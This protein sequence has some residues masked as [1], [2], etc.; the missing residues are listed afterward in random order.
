MKLLYEP[1][2]V[3]FF[4]I[5]RGSFWSICA[6]RAINGQQLN[7]HWPEKEIVNENPSR[8]K[9]QDNFSRRKMSVHYL[10][11][12]VSRFSAEFFY[13]FIW[14]NHGFVHSMR[15]EWYWFYM[16]TYHGWLY[17]LHLP[18]YIY[19]QLMILYMNINKLWM[20]SFWAFIITRQAL[21]SWQHNS[22]CSTLGV[23]FVLLIL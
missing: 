5:S 13:Q 8:N 22:I 18:R 20:G 15:P 19:N 6:K 9:S 7:C 12:I 17:T 14:Y 21:V 10:N 11:N 1:V 23:L 16:S 4:S 3:S 2:K